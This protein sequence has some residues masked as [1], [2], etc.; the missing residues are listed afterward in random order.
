MEIKNLL[1]IGVGKTG[2][3][4]LNDMMNLDPRYVGLFINS[5]KGDMENLENFTKENS[6]AIPQTNGSGKNRDKAREYILRWKES[7][8]ELMSSYSEFD[9]IVFYF[10]MDGGTGSGSVPTLAALTKNLFREHY[11]KDVN[12]IAVGTTPNAAVGIN[13]LRNA[14]DCWNDIVKLMNNHKDEDG[15][16]M[17]YEDG[18]EVTPTIN[19]LYLIDNNKRN[20]VYE[21]INAEAVETLHLAFNFNTLNTT[22][23]LDEN[24]SYNI[25]V[26]RG[27][28]FLLRLEEADSEEQAILDAKE[29][30]V[31]V[32]PREEYYNPENVGIA[33]K[34]S[35]FDTHNV[36]D[37]IGTAKVDVYPAPIDDEDDVD[38]AIFYG[39]IRLGLIKDY[40]DA[41]SQIIRDREKQLEKES[42]LDDDLIVSVKRDS[43]AVR[44]TTVSATKT[45]KK[46]KPSAAGKSRRK[47]RGVVSDDMFK[48]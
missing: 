27:Y 35:M 2:N 36:I 4:L 17:V 7:F 5:A 12:I 28:N 1:Q 39:G 41:M 21:E 10:S 37:L 6:F 25:N 48:F 32:I 3:V 20:G 45:V 26:S 29:R 38:G 44:R 46:E 43:S 15:N 14:Q 30:S 13:G 33:L 23:D 31:F 24:D 18:T 22:G 16:I 9:T 19:T 40:I 8:F 11:G 47:V 34:D 42:E